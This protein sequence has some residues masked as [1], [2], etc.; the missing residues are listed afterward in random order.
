MRHGWLLSGDCPVCAQSFVVR[1]RESAL[2]VVSPEGA[3]AHR[4]PASSY[5]VHTCSTACSDR[6]RAAPAFPPTTPRDPTPMSTTIR[7][8]AVGDALFPVDRM[9]GRFV[10]RAPDRSP[11]PEGV[12]VEDSP[13]LRRGIRA[14]SLELV[15]PEVPS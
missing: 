1:T 8:R 5:A 6:F 15:A 3:E 10:G 12:E 7:V 9:P 4:D 13:Y 11:I 14:G 2:D